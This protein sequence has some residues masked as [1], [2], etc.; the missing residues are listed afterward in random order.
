MLRKQMTSLA[1]MSSDPTA[2]RLLRRVAIL[3]TLI[4][5]VGLQL[6]SSSPVFSSPSA[7][8]K[9]GSIE[10]LGL[11]TKEK[12]SIRGIDV[13]GLRQ[14][15]EGLKEQARGLGLRAQGLKAKAQG[16]RAR[17][18]RLRPL[19]R[20]PRD[21]LEKEG[22]EELRGLNSKAFR[23]SELDTVGKKEMVRQRL[24]TQRLLKHKTLVSAPCPPPHL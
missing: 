15:A 11:S 12:S 8:T 19:A 20:L 22:A 13:E 2:S 23:A 16:I 10:A 3:A 21:S 1:F 7:E 5:I 9:V 17:V 6:L 4:S 24:K 18:N 14:R